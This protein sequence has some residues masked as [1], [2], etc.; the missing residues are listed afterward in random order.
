MEVTQIAIIEDNQEKNKVLM[1]NLFNNFIAMIVLLIIRDS[2]ATDIVPV[3]SSYLFQNL[4]EYFCN[5]L[6]LE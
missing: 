6:A 2:V 3:V 4:G 5:M 1:A